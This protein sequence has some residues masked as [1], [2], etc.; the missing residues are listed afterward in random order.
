[1]E[2]RQLSDPWQALA[3][4]RIQEAYDAGAFDQLPGFGQPLPDLGDPND[5]LWWVRRKLQ[6]EGFSVLPP[7][8]RERQEIQQAV[9]EALSLND[10]DEVRCRLEEINQRLLTQPRLISWGPASSQTLLPV[11]RLLQLWR[12]RRRSL[13]T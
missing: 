2:S 7:A 11:E 6:R 3:E 8:L 5:D 4:Q 12:T 13:S 1:M 9:E 10:P